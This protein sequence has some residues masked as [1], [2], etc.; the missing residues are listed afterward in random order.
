MTTRNL[1]IGFCA[2]PLK[3]WQDSKGAMKKKNTHWLQAMKN[4]FSTNTHS[5]YTHLAHGY[6]QTF[7]MPWCIRPN[8]LFKVL[9]KF[10]FITSHNFSDFLICSCAQNFNQY[11]FL[12]SYS[13][14]EKKGELY[15][16]KTKS[17]IKSYC[18]S[19]ISLVSRPEKLYKFRWYK[20]MY[21]FSYYKFRTA[22][23]CGVL[24]LK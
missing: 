16:R 18:S 22:I 5:C 19:N 15:K 8:I 4:A 10:W 11:T 12:S 3:G 24:Y 20:I 23:I 14:R 17:L 2:V 21:W 9:S 6:K 13:L 1:C 7:K